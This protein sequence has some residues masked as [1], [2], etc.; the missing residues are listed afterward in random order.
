[1]PPGNS[2]GGTG[3][4]SNRNLRGWGGQ[5]KI[6]SP[7]LT[8]SHTEPGNDEFEVYSNILDNGGQRQSTWTKILTYS[9]SAITYILPQYFEGGSP[10][11]VIDSF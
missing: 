11:I 1:M 2:F 4:Y 7:N 6:F 8:G 5:F 10:T 3:I 9:G